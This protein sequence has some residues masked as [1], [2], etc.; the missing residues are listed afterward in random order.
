M[1]R[2]DRTAAQTDGEIAANFLELFRRMKRYVRG[3]LPPY[4]ENGM[5]EEKVR[6]LAALRFLGKSGLKTLAAYDGLSSSSQCILLGQLVDVGLAKREEDQAD[7]RNVFYDLTERGHDVIN[8]ALAMRTE[9]L[10][11]R[12][13]RLGKRE[14]TRFAKALTVAL[15]A[16]DRLPGDESAP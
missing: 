14:K 11:G 3:E 5:N 6:C 8:S 10:C 2:A 15:A 1:R 13:T 12:L 4:V 9:F 7:R 16:L